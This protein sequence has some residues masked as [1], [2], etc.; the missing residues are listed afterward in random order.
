MPGRACPGQGHCRDKLSSSSP[1]IRGTCQLWRPRDLGILQHGLT[2]A[3]L[4]YEIVEI[5]HDRVHWYS[6]WTF[7]FAHPAGVAA[8]EH[9][10][11]FLVSGQL[12][13][14]PVAEL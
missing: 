1:G 4:G 8:V 9:A 3:F 11:A 2:F 12:C 10:A 5:A 13:L 14:I 6:L 7:W